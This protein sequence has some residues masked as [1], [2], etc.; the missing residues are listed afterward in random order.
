MLEFDVPI[1]QIRHFIEAMCDAH[2]LTEEQRYLLRVN[3][4][5]IGVKL[6]YYD[7]EQQ[8]EQQQKEQQRQKR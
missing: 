6:R 8:Q 2:E 7:Q 3:L 4:R 5:E 1:G